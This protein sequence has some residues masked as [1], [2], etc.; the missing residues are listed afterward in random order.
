M[1]DFSLTA[2]QDDT[3][4]IE[5]PQDA[6]A[7]EILTFTL[8]VPYATTISSPDTFCWRDNTDVTTSVGLN[9]AASAAG[10]VL[11]AA[12][13]T[14]TAVTRGRYVVSFQFVNGSQTELKK[15]LLRVGKQEDAP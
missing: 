13:M 2:K 11:T 14:P 3:W 7:G 12:A 5:N 9:G 10:N 8:T 6:I 1:P 15:L 4:V